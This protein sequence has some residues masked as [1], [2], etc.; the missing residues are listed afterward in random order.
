[1][2]KNYLGYF[3]SPYYCKRALRKASGCYKL[4]KVTCKDGIVY[5]VKDEF[6]NLYYA[7]C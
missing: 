2:C 5:S 7:N 3:S 4:C 1:M 6:G